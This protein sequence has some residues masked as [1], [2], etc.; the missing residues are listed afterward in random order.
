MINMEEIIVRKSHYFPNSN[1]FSQESSID[2]KTLEWKFTGEQ[3]IYSLEV[4]PDKLVVYKEGKY[5]F[6]VKK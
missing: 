4:F 1:W 2:A 6:T 3:G 5:T